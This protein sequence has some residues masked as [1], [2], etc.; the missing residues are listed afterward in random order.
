MRRP[1]AVL[2][3]C[4]AGGLLALLPLGCSRGTD[5]SKG[6]SAAK[7]AG[8]VEPTAPKPEYAFAAG[9]EEEYPEIA[10]F[11]RQMLETALAGDY[12][13]YRKLV[14][15]VADPESRARF[16]SVLN[17]MKSLSIELIEEVELAQIPPPT[18]LVTARAELRP[19][20]RVSLRRGSNSRIAILVLQEEGEW[21]M[22]LAPSELQPSAETTQPATAPATTAPSYPWQQD[23]DY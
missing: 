12:A 23:G 15:R 8:H 3:V 7:Q 11:V 2:R 19:E 10:G 17:A 22:M 14:A 20:T 13:G 18:Y 16:E 1:E 5:T 9:L 21:R 6:S 4:V